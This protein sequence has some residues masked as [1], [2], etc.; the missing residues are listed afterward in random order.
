MQ[1]SEKQLAQ[2]Y[3]NATSNI[4]IYTVAAATKTIVRN[5]VFCNTTAVDIAVRLFAV[6]DG[7]SAGVENSL[8]YNFDIP[9]NLSISKN[10]YLILD[11]PGDF[12]VAYVSAQ[13]VC[14]T[15]S[16]AELT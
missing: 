7:G 3:P 9:A 14:F 12:L 1:I 5:I 8:F 13:G 2:S 11:T 4:T 10:L 6:P 15:I 16:G